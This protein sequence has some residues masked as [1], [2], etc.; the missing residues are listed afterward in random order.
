SGEKLLWVGRPVQ[1]MVLT[2]LD[3]YLIPF[4]VVWCGFV[5]SVVYLS[6]QHST[7]RLEGLALSVVVGLPFIGLGI[8][9][10]IGRFFADRLYRSRLIY[11]VTDRRTIIVSGVSRRSAQS[12]Y[13]STLSALKFEERADGSGTIYFA[14]QPSYW[15]GAVPSLDP[16]DGTQFFRIADVKK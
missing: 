3:W 5:L 6:W 16:A 12:I 14:D 1:G 10:F 13:L 9:L 7:E 8:Y 11:G 15:Y 4:S 2:P